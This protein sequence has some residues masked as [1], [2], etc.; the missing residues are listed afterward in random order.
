M[1]CVAFLFKPVHPLFAVVVSGLSYV[2]AV[3]MLKLFTPQ[4]ASWLRNI[5]SLKG[6]GAVFARLRFL[7]I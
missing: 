4:E 6:I 7:R 3:L 5:G 2:V 1:A